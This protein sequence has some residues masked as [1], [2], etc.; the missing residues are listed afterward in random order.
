MPRKASSTPAVAKPAVLPTKLQNTRKKTK[1]DPAEKSK[2]GKVQPAEKSKKGRECKKDPDRDEDPQAV[3]DKLEK[4]GKIPHWLSPE[5]AAEHPEPLYDHIVRPVWVDEYLKTGQ[6]LHFVEK[7]PMVPPSKR[8]FICTAHGSKELCPQGMT[9]SKESRPIISDVFGKSNKASKGI[10]C[11][12]SWCR[13]HYQRGA[14]EKGTAY[15]TNIKIGPGTHFTAIQLQLWRINYHHPGTV[16]NIGLRKEETERFEA[17]KKSIHDPALTRLPSVPPPA[18]DGKTKK[19]FYQAPCEFF[20]KLEKFFG[21]DKTTDDCFEAMECIYDGMEA[22]EIDQVPGIQ[23][24]PIL[25]ESEVAGE[26]KGK[27]RKMNDRAAAGTAAKKSK[28]DGNVAAPVA[29]KR[30][31]DGGPDGASSGK[32]RK[33]A[34]P[35]DA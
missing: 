15:E 1:A 23:L 5:E 34:G 6:V 9:D 12:I 29:K 10:N 24:L 7:Y 11:W 2:Q 13:V 31:V 8:D 14:Y 30:K 28:A 20:Q 17:W 27:K 35:A 19:G 3:L 26:S 25:P 16:W 18:E 22:E 21:K 33:A 4:E 32:K